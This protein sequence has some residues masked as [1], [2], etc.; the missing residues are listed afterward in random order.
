MYAVLSFESKSFESGG[1]E[2]S[3]SCL[4]KG[5]A[6]RLTR[7]AP[8]R[9]ASEAGRPRGRGGGKAACVRVSPHCTG[10]C[11]RDKEP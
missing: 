9:A 5:S 7:P 4:G 10:C 2:R 1:G 3:R 11:G 8:R 6:G